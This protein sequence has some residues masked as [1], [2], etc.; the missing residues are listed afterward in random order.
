MSS[1]SAGVG[2][3][4]VSWAWAQSFSGLLQLGG[5]TAHEKAVLRVSLLPA[6]AGRAASDSK[7]LGSTQ[8]L[9]S[10]AHPHPSCG[11]LPCAP[12]AS[13]RCHTLSWLSC[14]IPVC[15][16]HPAASLFCALPMAPAPPTSTVVPGQPSLRGK[17]ALKNNMGKK[18]LPTS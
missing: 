5:N 18:S 7:H 10:H 1:G 2:G 17:P 12:V 4:G 13:P 3:S 6:T 14:H 15:L 8:R 16:S 11:R 9:T